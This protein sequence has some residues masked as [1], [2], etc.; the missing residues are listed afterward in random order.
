MQATGRWRFEEQCASLPGKLRVEVH[1]G[2][3]AA[4]TDMFDQ[5]QVNPHLLGGAGQTIIEDALEF[6]RAFQVQVTT[7]AQADT[8]ALLFMHDFEH[9]LWDEI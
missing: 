5:A 8:I 2:P 6:A 7:E 1:E 9:S 4:G 3:N